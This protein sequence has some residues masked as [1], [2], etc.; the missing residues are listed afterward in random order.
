MNKTFPILYPTA[1]HPQSSDQIFSIRG[2]DHLKYINKF[3]GVS[4]FVFTL[5]PSGALCS[6]V[7]F[8]ATNVSP[9]WGYLYVSPSGAQRW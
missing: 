9:L 7:I 4:S 8:M 6:I 5:R 2:N 1:Q 3:C